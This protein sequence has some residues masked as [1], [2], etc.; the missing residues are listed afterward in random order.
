MKLK[1]NNKNYSI[2]F[3]YGA[4][5]LLCKKW[6]V[7]TMSGLDPHLKK[8]NFKEGEEPGFEQLDL[9][10]DLVAAG[11]VNANKKAVIDRDD[12]VTALMQDL[13]K[14]APII[15]LFAES[16]PQEVNPEKRGN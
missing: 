13:N 14:M 1:V 4:I 2:K 12:V 8:L 7:K 6:G 11:I 5:K 16:M 3:G 10:G 15:E 9:L